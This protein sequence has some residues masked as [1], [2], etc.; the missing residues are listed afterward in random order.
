MTRVRVVYILR[1]TAR[2]MRRNFA[3]T[4]AAVV[5]AA[6]SLSLVGCSLLLRTGV[7]NATARW[8]GGVEFIVF[9]DPYAG[10]VEIDQVRDKLQ[11]DPRVADVVFVDQAAAYDEFTEL[12][13]DE[14]GVLD[15]V[16]VDEVPA[17]FKVVPVDASS[18]AVGSLVT[19]YEARPGVYDVVAALDVVKTLERLSAALTTGA[20]VVAGLLLFAAVALI[21]NAVRVTVSARRDEIAVMHLIGSPP[22]YVRMPFVLEGLICGTSGAVAAVGA[23]TVAGSLLT[24]LSD[25]G[26]VG[27]GL[28]AG[29]T[30]SGSDRFTVSAIVAVIGVAA[31]AVGAAIAVGRHLKH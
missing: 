10:S 12:F 23:V 24:R 21:L 7:E 2:N 1:D 19:S 20:L 14:P 30:V 27:S 3:V 6:V 9:M 18:Q 17:S 15:A 29:F 4:L 25:A 22:W 5:T 16:T 31:G 26:G 28:L 11:A 13:K 8:Q